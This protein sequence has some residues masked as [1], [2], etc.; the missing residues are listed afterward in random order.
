MPCLYNVHF[1][2]GIATNH[3]RSES[4]L[5][6]HGLL[7]KKELQRSKCGLAVYKDA[8]VQLVHTPSCS[9]RILQAYSP[10]LNW[11]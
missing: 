2:E 8:V 11:L 5:E 1:C 7:A 10:T 4:S 3:A 9:S 6:R